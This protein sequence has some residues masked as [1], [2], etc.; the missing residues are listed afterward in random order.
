VV[1]VVVV[2]VVVGGGDMDNIL[3]QFPLTFC[4]HT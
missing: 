4:E 2:V 1:V 3:P